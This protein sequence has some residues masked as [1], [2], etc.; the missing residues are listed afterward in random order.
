M[1]IKTL[2]VEF[3]TACNSRCVM[4]DYW[5]GSAHETIDPELV[6]SVL[7]EQAPLGLERVYFTGGECLVWAE[8]LFSLCARIRANFPELRLGLI[9]NGILLEK[10]HCEVG[11]LFQKVIVSLDTLEPAR[12]EKIRGIDG[13]EKV[14]EGIR[15][16]K[17][18]SPQTQ[19]NLRVLVLAENLEELPKIVAYGAAEN[20]SRVSFIPEDTGSRYAFGRMAQGGGAD[21][22]PPSPAELRRVIDQI[23]S[24]GYP[25]SGELLRPDLEDLERVYAIYSGAPVCVPRCNKASVSCVIGTDGQVSPCFFIPGKQ[26]ISAGN[27]LQAILDSAEYRLCVGEIRAHGHPSCGSCACPKELS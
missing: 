14:K 26:K 19:V 9:T 24:A 16:L 21:R 2:H 3:T 18:Y 17:A 20:L 8:R 27:S 25:R 1:G 7:S 4:C 13:A 15:A 23:R 22:K 12:Y 6:L 10:Y 11:D 5:K